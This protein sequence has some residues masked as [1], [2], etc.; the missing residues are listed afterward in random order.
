MYDG[1]VSIEFTQL[2]PHLRG[3]LAPL[4]LA[5]KVVPV[6]ESGPAAGGGEQGVDV[7]GEDLFALGNVHGGQAVTRRNL[8]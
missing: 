4:A 8:I 3:I 1:W 2:P 5:F 7:L 6:P